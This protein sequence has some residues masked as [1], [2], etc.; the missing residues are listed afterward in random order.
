MVLLQWLQH[1]S[2]YATAARGHNTLSNLLN[3]LYGRLRFLSA[4]RRCYQ[5][6]GRRDLATP[7]LRSSPGLLFL[8]MQRICE[9]YGVSPTSGSIL[10][11]HVVTGHLLPI[12][13]SHVISTVCRSQR[14]AWHLSRPRRICHGT[15]SD[16]TST[17]SHADQRT[18][19][20]IQ[21]A[22]RS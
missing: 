15:R 11:G 22:T 12:R 2:I 5:S 8:L 3:L 16:V 20:D 17:T 6:T 10:V 21:H 14:R 7:S 9:P 4:A 18:V 13:S 19:A 1:Q